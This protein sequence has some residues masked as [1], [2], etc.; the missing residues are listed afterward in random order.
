MAPDPSPPSPAADLP[1][2]VTVP[3]LASA[4]RA[5]QEV[6]SR[7]AGAGERVAVAVTDRHG[8]LVAFGRMDDGA[9]RWVRLAQRK[10]Y[11][12][13]LL[14]R[15][16]EVLGKELAARGRSLLDHG[17]PALTTLPGG[18]P[19][20]ARPGVALAGVGIAGDAGATR[21]V[22]LATLAA[23]LLGDPT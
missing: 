8:D 10:A 9:P 13:A 2:P 19:L 14:G 5:V 21:E 18:A 16:T 17:D 23:A 22:E 3:T 4:Q 20:L 12:A 6:L 1:L 15:S 7:A 11:T